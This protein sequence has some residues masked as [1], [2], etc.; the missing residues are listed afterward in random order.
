MSLICFTNGSLVRCVPSP[1]WGRCDWDSPVQRLLS[2]RKVMRSPPN[3]GPV[4]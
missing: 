3:W 1:R 2:P 4:D